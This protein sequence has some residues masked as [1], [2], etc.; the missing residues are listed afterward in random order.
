MVYCGHDRKR[1]H[2]P[3]F[4]QEDGK[5]QRGYTGTDMDNITAGKINRSDGGKETVVSPYHMCQRIINNN[6]PENNKQ[7][8]CLKTHSSDD[9]TGDQRRCDDSEHHLETANTRCGIVS[10]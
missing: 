1:V 5:H 6:G 2:I 4:D 10:A 3:V 8:Q 9:R 7:K